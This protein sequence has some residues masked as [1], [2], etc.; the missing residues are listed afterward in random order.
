MKARN[1]I[2]IYLGL[3]V[4]TIG[5]AFWRAWSDDSG[6]ALANTPAS[7][8]AVVVSASPATPVPEPVASRPRAPP[9]SDAKP[10]PQPPPR[11]AKMR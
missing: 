5:V 2:L 11:P 7:K 4:L 9:K 1:L 3:I 10:G 6:E 8:G